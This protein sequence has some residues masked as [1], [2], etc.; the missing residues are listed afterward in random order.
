MLWISCLGLLPQCSTDFGLLCLHFHFF[1]DS[2][3]KLLELVNEFSKVAG[4][5]INIQ[6]SIAFLYA[7]NELTEREI[8]KTISFT[9]ATKRIKYLGTNLINGVKDLYTGNYKTVKKEIEEY[10]NKWRHILCSWI[11]RINIIKMSTHPKQS[12]VSMQFLSR[13]Q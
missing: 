5:K 7:N 13:F 8:K 1:H 3:N 12:I 11:G 4:Y 9:I 6:K 2:T 10:T